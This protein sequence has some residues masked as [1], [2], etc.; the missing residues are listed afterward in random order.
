MAQAQRQKEIT[1]GN[2][3]FEWGPN[4]EVPDDD[5]DVED[6]DDGDIEPQQEDAPAG[7][8]V[9]HEPPAPPNDV[10]QQ[11]EDVHDDH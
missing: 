1:G 11:D 6:T 10:Q 3:L 5:A 7:E 9:V 2:L 4:D 8:A